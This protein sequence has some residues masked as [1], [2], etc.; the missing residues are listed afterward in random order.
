MYKTDKI[1]IIILF[2]AVFCATFFVDCQLKSSFLSGVMAW[3][4]IVF[5]FLVSTISTLFGSKFTKRLNELEDHSQE[6]HC[7]QLQ[8]LKRYFYAAAL[9]CLFSTLL[10]LA[11]ELIPS[12]KT[13]FQILI[14]FVVVDV[15]LTWKIVRL[16]LKGLEEEAKQ[17]K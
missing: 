10:A 4:G 11:A 6:I 8:I 7:T 14:A 16:L 2:V 1:I 15:Y 17:K 13:I 3:G 12:I 9:T 5:G